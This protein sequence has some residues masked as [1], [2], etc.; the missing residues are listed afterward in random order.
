MKK[1]LVGLLPRRVRDELRALLEC[2]PELQV[3]Y[4]RLLVTGAFA[5]RRHPARLPL[6]SGSRVLF[7]C[8]GNILRSAF[9]EA[10]FRECLQASGRFP[11]V[12]TGSAGTHAREDRSADD[13]GIR[14]APE[15]GVYLDSHRARRITPALLTW[16]THI[17]AMDRQNFA[18]ILSV[19][20]GAKA[21]TVLLTDFASARNGELVVPDPYMSD[22]AGVR[23]SYT[24]IASLLDRARQVHE[25][26]A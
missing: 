5:R 25:R 16:A 8:Y 4:L 22:E 24:R 18:G 11:Q 17:V 9:A 1:Y 26:R 21:R 12:E 10:Y 20:P 14:V 6:E 7:V 3:I 15:F 2:P 13:R 19:S 23:S